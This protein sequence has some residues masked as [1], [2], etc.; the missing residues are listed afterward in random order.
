MARY[1]DSDKHIWQTERAIGAIEIGDYHPG[2]QAVRVLLER[3]VMDSLGIPAEHNNLYYVNAGGYSTVPTY[4][5]SETGPH[6]AALCTRTRQ[7]MIA[8]RHYSGTLDF[9]PSGNELFMGLR[10]SGDDGTTITLR[11][12][13]QL[14]LP[15]DLPITG[16]GSIQVVDA[17]GN[18]NPMPIQDHSIHLITSNLPVYLRLSPGQDVGPTAIDYGKNLAKLAT[19]HYSA[20]SDGD[21]SLLTNGIF[22]APHPSDPHQKLWTGD[23]PTS[24]QYLEIDFAQPTAINRLIVFTAH[25][26]NPY[27]ALLDYDIQ[28]RV[29]NQWTTV[30]QVRSPC[31]PSDPV[32]TTDA[33][34]T[35]WYLDQNLFENTF[36]PVTTDKLR[37]VVLRTT[38]GFMADLIDTK[39]CSFV[40]NAQHLMLREIEVYGP[41]VAG[42]AGGAA[43]RD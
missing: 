12:Y 29:G 36:P 37:L 6:P 27:C 39:A 19:F 7:A 9:G 17:F 22:E 20:P 1:G 25:A 15:L 38:L 13:G 31:P 33:L 21:F 41:D 4:V 24:P 3:D 40:P 35:S 8:N 43:R 23:M 2:T 10:Y 26:D 16:S 14:G 18:V 42:A 34:A 32:R 5:W 30:Q 28:V 11:N